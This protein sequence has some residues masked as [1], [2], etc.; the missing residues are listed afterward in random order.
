MDS[1]VISVLA[2]CQNSYSII[3]FLQKLRCPLMSK[4]NMKPLSHLKDTVPAIKKEKP[5]VLPLPLQFKQSSFSTVVNFL[6]KSCGPQSTGKEVPIQRK[7]ILR[8][9]KWYWFFYPP[10]I[11]NLCYNKK[12][13]L[14]FLS[15]NGLCL[16]YSILPK[17]I[18][19]CCFVLSHN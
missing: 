16:K 14:S 18:M 4:E 11:Y 15:V 12:L 2:K 9:C 6:D 19:F 17:T 13:N 10:E 7:F 3:V 8:Y 5:Q 1:R